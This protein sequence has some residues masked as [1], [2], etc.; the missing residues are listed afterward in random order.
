M[1]TQEIIGVPPQTC[2]CCHHAL[3]PDPLV[4]RL[5]NWQRRWT[6]RLGH[7]LDQEH[8]AQIAAAGPGCPGRTLSGTVLAAVSLLVMLGLLVLAGTGALFLVQGALPLK[9]VGLILLALA[10]QLRPRLG[11]VSRVRESYDEIRRD[12]APALFALID[13][14]ADRVGAPRPH[15]VLLESE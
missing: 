4:G 6:H 8:F 5:T 3:E 11:R 1:L 10:V 9:M 14:T 2:P 13:R 15:H 7:R 12:R